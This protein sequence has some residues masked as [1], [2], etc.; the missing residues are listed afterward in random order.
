MSPAQRP[1]PQ[2]SP[3]IQA[4][5]TVAQGSAP[6][7][8]SV[9]PPDATALRPVPGSHH[10]G[11]I[12]PLHATAGPGSN[13]SVVGRAPLVPTGTPASPNGQAASPFGIQPVSASMP[14][15]SGHPMIEHAP[16]P[17]TQ[18]AGPQGRRFEAVGRIAENDTPDP[19][20]PPHVLLDPAGKP[21]A[22]LQEQPGID[23][24]RFLH[25]A[26][27]VDGERY[28]HADFPIPLIVVESLTPIALPR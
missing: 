6:S 12:E 22:Y 14:A 2:P 17:S 20:L 5:A 7:P 3:I 26:M 24:D 28:K 15:S 19:E 21:V 25:A 10:H 8:L 13:G 1:M 4:G 16:R 18:P 23:L 27:G 9:V 11:A